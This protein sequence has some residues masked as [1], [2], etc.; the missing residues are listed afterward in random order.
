MFLTHNSVHETVVWLIKGIYIALFIQR[1]AGTKNPEIE[2]LPN[3]QNL[4]S[5]LDK[6]IQTSQSFSRHY[7]IYNSGYWTI[8][9]FFSILT[10]GI[11]TDMPTFQKEKRDMSLPSVER[12]INVMLHREI[13]KM[14]LSTDYAQVL[15]TAVKFFCCIKFIHLF[16][17]LK[18]LNKR[19]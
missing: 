10:F 8:T 12:E 11:I 7:Q 17:A 3:P 6:I 9:L 4:I 5:K 16:C 13:C 15:V 1:L 2:C 19:P 14:Y 18:K